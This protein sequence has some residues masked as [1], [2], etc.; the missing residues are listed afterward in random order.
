MNDLSELNWDEI[1]SYLPDSERYHLLWLNDTYYTA[2]LSY[3]PWTELTGK[4]GK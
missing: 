3:Y 2:I 1:G 4:S